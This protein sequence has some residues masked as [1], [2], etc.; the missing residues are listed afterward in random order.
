MAPGPVGSLREGCAAALILHMYM[1]ATI[2]VHYY[3]SADNPHT[4]NIC[5]LYYDALY[6][7]INSHDCTAVSRDTCMLIRLK[8]QS[9][10]ITFDI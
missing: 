6:M 2:L 10:V 7:T 3:C 9:K 8:L 4:D 5:T 1:A